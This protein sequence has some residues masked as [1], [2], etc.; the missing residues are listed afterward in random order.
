MM[1]PSELSHRQIS[2]FGGIA[3]QRCSFHPGER[4]FEERDPGDSVLFIEQGSVQVGMS[5]QTIAILLAGS[6]FGEHCLEYP[7]YRV[8]SATALEDT[9]VCRIERDDMLEALRTIPTLRE[10]FLVDLIDQQEKILY[11]L[12]ELEWSRRASQVL[13][14]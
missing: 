10:A 7:G 1:K 2:D 8:N 11:L 13:M 6:F 3:L 9:V 5:N 4:I 12:L 14:E